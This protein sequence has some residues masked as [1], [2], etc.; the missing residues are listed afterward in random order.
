MMAADSPI[1][2]EIC[3]DCGI[4]LPPAAENTA[5]HRYIGASPS[6]W[7]RFSTLLNA[8]EPP[9]GNGRL[10]PLLLDAYCVQHH[11]APS[12]QAINSVAV[13]ALVL[14]GVLAAGVPPD[15]ALWIRR[16]AL[17]DDAPRSKHAR[18]HW[19]TPPDAGQML[20]IGAI[21]NAPTPAARSA[22][23][24]AYV[25]SVWQAWS[26]PHG[27]TLANWYAAYVA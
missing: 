6:C 21:L 4:A 9:M 1:Q 25:Q 8:G 23:L 26:A 24:Q 14:H 2:A 22:Q 10:N 27:A 7:Q 17:R 5:V 20:T 18:F 3:P 11:G 16:R 19:L 15:S 12:P 13:H